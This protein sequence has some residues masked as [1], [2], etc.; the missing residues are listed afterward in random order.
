MYLVLKDS[1]DSEVFLCP[2]KF[3]DDVGVVFKVD[4]PM[5]ITGSKIKQN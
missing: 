2:K 4:D 1:T 3:V 5:E